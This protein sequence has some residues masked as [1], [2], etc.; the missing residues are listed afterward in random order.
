MQNGQ[1][2]L[3]GL[4]Q[5]CCAKQG[6]PPQ[7]GVP[8]T[9]GDPVNS[10]LL[11]GQKDLR[12]SAGPSGPCHWPHLRQV[13]VGREVEQ[14]EERCL[15]PPGPLQA[16]ILRACCVSYSPTARLP[17]TWLKPDR[18]SLDKNGVFFWERCQPSFQRNKEQ[19]T[20]Q[21]TGLTAW[22]CMADAAA[23]GCLLL[24]HGECWAC[25][26]RT[27]SHPPSTRTERRGL[28]WKLVGGEQACTLGGQA[29]CLV[30]MG[31]TSPH[32]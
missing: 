10:K 24:A 7:P 18:L 22:A 27:S 11:C 21:S 9:T 20:P 14:P 31:R 2:G 5:P 19:A 30:P 15:R 26:S 6:P 25:V 23:A 29:P 13:N 3:E 28:W 32:R 16:G 1:E 8:W 17:P 12:E 4:P